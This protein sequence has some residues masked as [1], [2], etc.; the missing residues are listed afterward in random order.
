MLKDIYDTIIADNAEK[1]SVP[2]TWI[3]AIIGA[4]SDFNPDAYRA[5]PQIHDGSSGLMQILLKTAR[6]LGFTGDA[7]AL[8]DPMVNISLGTKLLA[9]LRARY[10]DDFNAVYSAYNS[11]LATA[12]KTNSTVAAHLNRALMYLAEVEASVT[13]VNGGPAVE[14][15]SGGID[16]ML[17]LAAAAAAV[18]YFF[19]R[20]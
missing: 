14:D 16:I 4:E 13:A 6:G 10:G 5:E 18:W 11:G 12:Y 1:Y 8:F 3:K 7:A 20:R 2:F 9:Q 19:I 15:Q 17:L